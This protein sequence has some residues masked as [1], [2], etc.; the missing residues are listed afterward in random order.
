MSFK[1]PTEEPAWSADHAAAL[2]QFLNGTTGQVLLQRMH[3]MRPLGPLAISEVT[4]F[5]PAKR[6]AASDQLIG[7]DIA[8][9]E[10]IA[11]TVSPK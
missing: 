7:Y 4:E 10:L 6:T 8:I 5:N 2:R 9:Q 3:W 1:I 11:H